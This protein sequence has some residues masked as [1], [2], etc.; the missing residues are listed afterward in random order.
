MRSTLELFVDV[1]GTLTPMDLEE[2]MVTKI[3]DCIYHLVDTG[4]IQSALKTRKAIIHKYQTR[5][6][7]M[8]PK[9]PPVTLAVTS[10]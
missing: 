9:P 1:V 10:E 3:R 6:K 5:Q 2:E 4:E 8:K 7:L